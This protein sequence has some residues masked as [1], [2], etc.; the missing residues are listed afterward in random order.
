MGCGTDSLCYRDKEIRWK[1][2]KTGGSLRWPFYQSINVQPLR[3]G[4]SGDPSAGA[5]RFLCRSYRDVVP[6]RVVFVCYYKVAQ[7]AITA[8]DLIAPG[9]PSCLPAAPALAAAAAATTPTL[10]TATGSQY[11]LAGNSCVGRALCSSSRRRRRGRPRQLKSRAVPPAAATQRQ[12]GWPAPQSAWRRS[13][14]RRKMILRAK[15]DAAALGS[16]EWPA[17]TDTK[18]S[19]QRHYVYNSFKM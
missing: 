19:A 7:L 15:T 3:C 18:E 1:P 17:A 9:V 2:H 6:D 5:A 16:A 11:R 10:C 4:A 8:V 14:R 12:E 13:L